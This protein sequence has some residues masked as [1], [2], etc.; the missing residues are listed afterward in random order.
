M[1][2]AN[3][4]TCPSLR[5]ENKSLTIKLEQIWKGPMIFAMKS[6]DKINPFRRPY[7][8]NTLM[9]I[10]MMIENL[11]DTILGVFIV[12]YFIIPHINVTLRRLMFLRG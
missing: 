4:E 2:F 3:Y 12:D 6:K 1:D 9:L 8:K 7:I 5:D 11:M 10:K